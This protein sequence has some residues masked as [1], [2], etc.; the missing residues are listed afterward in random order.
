MMY[1]NNSSCYNKESESIYDSDMVEA[2]CS[3]KFGFPVQW[4]AFL[5]AMS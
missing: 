2:Y 1:H 3:F 4:V 5:Q